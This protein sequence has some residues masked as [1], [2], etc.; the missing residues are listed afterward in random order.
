VLRG[1]G[2]LAARW[3]GSVFFIAA[4]RVPGRADTVKYVSARRRAAEASDV[5][6]TA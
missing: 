1:G 3:V 2:R 6:H 4:R 5:P